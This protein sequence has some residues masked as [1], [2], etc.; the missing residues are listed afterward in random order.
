MVGGIT[1]DDLNARLKAVQGFK[2]DLVIWS[3]VKDAI[4]F[5]FATPLSYDNDQVKAE[6][7]K[8]GFCV[9]EVDFDG[10]ISSPSDMHWVLYIGNQQLIDPWTGSTKSTGWYPIVKR[11]APC[12]KIS[13]VDTSLQ[14]L[15]QMYQAKGIDLSRPEGDV[16]GRVQEIF[17]GN[18]KY[19]EAVKQRDKALA[20]L[21]E[22]RGDSAKWE[23]NYLT[24]ARQINEL[25]KEIS[26]LNDKV[27][28]RDKEINE[29]ATRID[30]LEHQLDPEKVIVITKDD[31]LRLLEAKK[32]MLEAA[33]VWELIK[34][35]FSKTF[36]KIFS[37]IFRRAV[38]K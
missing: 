5:N 16:R 33:K 18:D 12:T 31:Y 10:K 38:N 2:D 22:A 19:K 25:K 8:N 24:A 7:E 4:P 35:I 3:K 30:S 34:A 20:D 15:R 6:I 29:L 11:F 17:D 13:V 9:V 32:K 23:E 36:G 27:T 1:P 28:D 26:D 14:W 37:K 21:A